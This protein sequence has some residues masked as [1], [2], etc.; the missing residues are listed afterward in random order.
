MVRLVA[1]L[2]G[3]GKAGSNGMKN[4][5][6]TGYRD[7]LAK[8]LAGMRPIVEEAVTHTDG[9]IADLHKQQ[10]SAKPHLVPVRHEADITA[11][12]F[13][14]AAMKAVNDKETELATAPYK[15]YVAALEPMK[16]ELE[17][18][19]DEAKN[20]HDDKPADQGLADAYEGAQG[21]YVEVAKV[22]SD[23]SPS[24]T[25]TGDPLFGEYQKSCR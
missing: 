2:A 19:R 9:L 20:A 3:C 16:H 1:A 23:P 14:L 8:E 21:V 4:E 17:H 13:K 15:A 10:A 24:P 6:C 22:V 5:I 18:L 7:S 11:E 25:L 12:K